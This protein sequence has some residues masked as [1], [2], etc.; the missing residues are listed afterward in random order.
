MSEYI[1]TFKPWPSLTGEG[2]VIPFFIRGVSPTLYRTG[3]P[4]LLA[5]IGLSNLRSLVS[6]TIA[7]GLSLVEVGARVR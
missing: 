6:G 4:R 1:S 5:A 2:H 3:P 7:L